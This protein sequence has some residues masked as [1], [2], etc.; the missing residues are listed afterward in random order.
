MFFINNLPVDSATLRYISVDKAVSDPPDVSSELK[1]PHD[2]DTKR[3]AVYWG[4]PHNCIL[5]FQHE[6]SF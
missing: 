1:S 3:V 4:N 6:V 5:F 2:I